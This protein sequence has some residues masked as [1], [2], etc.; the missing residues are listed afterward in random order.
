MTFGGAFVF[1]L[2][3]NISTVHLDPLRIIRDSTCIAD[4]DSLSFHKFTAFMYYKNRGQ[5][6]GL[7]YLTLSDISAAIVNS[8]LP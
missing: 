4:I 7:F 3:L 1:A 2:R 5:W 6:I 8:H